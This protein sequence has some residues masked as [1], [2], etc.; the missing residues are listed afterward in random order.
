MG[1]LDSEGALRVA[2]ARIA[3][4]DGFEAKGRFEESSIGQAQR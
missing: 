2:D 4:S 1:A 3:R